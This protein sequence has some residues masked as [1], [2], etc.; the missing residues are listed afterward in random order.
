MKKKGDASQ[1]ES[2]RSPRGMKLN[3]KGKGLLSQNQSPS[4]TNSALMRKKQKQLISYDENSFERELIEK[5]NEESSIND[6]SEIM[7]HRFNKSY[8]SGGKHRSV[9]PPNLRTSKTHLAKKA[10]KLEQKIYSSND[11][12]STCNNRESRTSSLSPTDQGYVKQ[13]QASKHRPLNKSKYSQKKKSK[14]KRNPKNPQLYQS[15]P[16]VMPLV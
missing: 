14:Q 7:S 12:C 16:L 2:K 4:P 15:S 1:I 8:K 9:K 10:T 3:Q 6:G 13:K 5:L 11:S